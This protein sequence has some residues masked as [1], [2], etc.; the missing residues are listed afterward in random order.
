[1]A[2]AAAKFAPEFPYLLTN[3]EG[4][5]KVRVTSETAAYLHNGVPSFGGTHLNPVDVD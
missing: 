3:T 2:A 5:K 1:V 4:L